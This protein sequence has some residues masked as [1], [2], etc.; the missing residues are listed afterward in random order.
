MKKKIDVCLT[1]KQPVPVWWLSQV[2]HFLPY[3]QIIIDQTSP[4]GKAR[5]QCIHQVQT[6]WFLFLDDDVIID[7][8]FFPMLTQYLKEDVGAISGRENLIG[9]GRCWDKVIN[10]LRQSAGVQDLKQ[11]E[12]GTTVCCIMKTVLVKDWFP[13]PPEL[14]AYE[15][16]ALTQHVLSKGYKW[17]IVPTPTAKHISWSWFMIPRK[18]FW[19][20]KG[21]KKTHTAR[22]Q[23][24]LLKRLMLSL[25]YFSKLLIRRRVGLRVFIYALY[26]NAWAVIGLVLC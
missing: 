16:Y 12:R 14:N 8:S 22:Q 24:R 17:L 10:D 19:N 6:E 11:G 1:T 4:L 23:I 25:A 2:K 9:F 5:Q 13:S 15:D 21:I 18:C 3:E 26:H 20:G 7:R